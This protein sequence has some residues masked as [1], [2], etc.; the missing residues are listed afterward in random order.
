VSALINVVDFFTQNLAADLQVSPIKYLR[1]TKQKSLLFDHL[2]S[3]S[4]R[5][6]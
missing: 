3:H 2:P 4:S 5:A 6:M 1:K